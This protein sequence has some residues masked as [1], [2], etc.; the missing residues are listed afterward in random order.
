MVGISCFTIDSYYWRF[1]YRLCIETPRTGSRLLQTGDEDLLELAKQRQSRAI[2]SSISHW[3]SLQW[4]FLSSWCSPSTTYSLW[5]TIGLA[6]IYHLGLT[7][8]RKP[9]N[10]RKKHSRKLLKGLK[11][12]LFQFRWG[13]HTEVCRFVPW[14][15]PFPWHCQYCR[16]DALAIDRGNAGPSSGCRRV[17]MGSLGYCSAS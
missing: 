14:P 8:K 15:V 6:V 11:S 13:K 12:H 1:V 3:F 9:K 2:W 17:A 10:A 16:N 7:D 4:R 5:N